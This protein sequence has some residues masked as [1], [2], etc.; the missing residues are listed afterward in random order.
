LELLEG[1]VIYADEAYT[2]YEDLLK[3]VDLRL[4]A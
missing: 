3:E 4:K 1:S 2:D